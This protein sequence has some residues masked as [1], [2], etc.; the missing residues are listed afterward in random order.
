V[1]N[2]VGDFTTP[3]TLPGEGNQ[4]INGYRGPGYA[5]TDFAMLKNNPIREW[6]TLQLRLEVFNLFNRPSL[7]GISGTTSSS[8]FGKATSQYNARFLQ[9]G[10]KLQF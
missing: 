8:S 2:S 1:F 10:A 4:V 3:A 5:N 7:G 9:L 6:A